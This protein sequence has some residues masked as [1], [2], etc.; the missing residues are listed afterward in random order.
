MKQSVRVC[1]KDIEGLKNLTYL[2]SVVQNNA[3]SYQEIISLVHGAVDLQTMSK[4]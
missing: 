4:R 1:V 2:V 3:A